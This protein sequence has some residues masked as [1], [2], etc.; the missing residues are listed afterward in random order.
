MSEIIT[1][2]IESFYLM[3][4][5]FML[6]KN[7]LLFVAIRYSTGDIKNMVILMLLFDIIVL[8]SLPLGMLLVRGVCIK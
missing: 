1:V 4:F 3:F 7:L 5:L 6:M 8:F 2:C